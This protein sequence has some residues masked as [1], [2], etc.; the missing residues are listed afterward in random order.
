[1]IPDK[2]LCG[3]FFSVI[4]YCAAL[5]NMKLPNNVEL[6]QEKQVSNPF[7]SSI[8]ISK[9]LEFVCRMTKILQIQ[10][11]LKSVLLEELLNHSVAAVKDPK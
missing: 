5:W 6:G 8:N 10:G 11:Y 1:M 2:F 9:Y 4:L 7:L 3:A